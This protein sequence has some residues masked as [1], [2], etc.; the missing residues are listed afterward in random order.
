MVVYLASRPQKAF[1]PPVTCE[2]GAKRQ[3][4]PNFFSLLFQSDTMDFF[5][6]LPGAKAPAAGL[7][8][9]PLHCF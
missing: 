2:G 4:L 3:T 1:F 8:L 9:R 6:F 7:V 5:F